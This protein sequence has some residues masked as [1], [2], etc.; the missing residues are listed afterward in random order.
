MTKSCYDAD[1]HVDIN[2]V[3]I[4]LGMSPIVD[5]VSV[6]YPPDNYP[7]TLDGRLVGYVEEDIV[8]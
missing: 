1:I 8:D 5:D 4:E 2:Q 7:V 3:L 6:V